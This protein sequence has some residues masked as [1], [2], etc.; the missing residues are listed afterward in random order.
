MPW[1]EIGY[2]VDYMDRNLCYIYLYLAYMIYKR[3]ILLRTFYI[4]IYQNSSTEKPLLIYH[5]YIYQ[6]HAQIFC[7]ILHRMAKNRNTRKMKR[8]SILT[9]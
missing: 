5:H 6:A 2:F 9:H 1:A 7:V 3:F 4:L 8:N